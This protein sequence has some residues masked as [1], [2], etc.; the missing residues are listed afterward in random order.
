MAHRQEHIYIMS[1]NNKNRKR[2]L[3]LVLA[4]VAV[5]LST[6]YSNVYVAVPYLPGVLYILNVTDKNDGN[7][8]DQNKQ[9]S[10]SGN[11]EEE[12]STSTSAV[13]HSS[14]QEETE[15][16]FTSTGTSSSS[17]SSSDTYYP[18]GPLYGCPSYAEVSQHYKEWI[19]Q[20]RSPNFTTPFPKDVTMKSLE[21][22]FQ[23]MENAAHAELRWYRQYTEEH[24]NYNTIGGGGCPPGGDTVV[25][26]QYRYVQLMPYDR[27][28]G[29][30]NLRTAW[31]QLLM[32]GQHTNRAAVF[33][34]SIQSFCY[35]LAALDGVPESEYA[36]EQWSQMKFHDLFRVNA[37]YPSMPD[38]QEPSFVS[39]ANGSSHN[40]PEELFPHVPIYNGPLRGKGMAQNEV[41][42][43]NQWKESFF[44]ELISRYQGVKLVLPYFFCDAFDTSTWSKRIQTLRAFTFSPQIQRIANTVLRYMEHNL[45]C[46]SFIS[47]HVRT[48]KI[49][50]NK[51]TTDI[52]PLERTIE[53]RFLNGTYE[54]QQ[55]PLSLCVYV[56]SSD[57]AL[58]QRISKLLASRNNSAAVGSIAVL[59]KYDV[60]DFADQANTSSLLSLPDIAMKYLPTVPSAID[61]AVA[62]QSDIHIGPHTS[63][64]D[65]TLAAARGQTDANTQNYNTMCHNDNDM[66]KIEK[67]ITKSGELKLFPCCDGTSRP[68]YWTC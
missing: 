20:L 7:N 66:S 56:L 43:K 15:E 64:F 32:Y 34:S 50:S 53:Q 33:E 12:D 55:Q 54:N 30:N 65:I 18:K 41:R 39:S 44:L 46:D 14:E 36:D 25:V 11:E 29:L 31:G 23:S 51:R 60:P 38:T 48:N 6:L 49:Y 59:N 26:P 22:I 10:K 4:F 2:S 67:G 68:C 42:R 17:Y 63:S 5:T 16:L 28:H 58:S 8:D 3:L 47:Y 19:S 9:R 37:S 57:P 52:R 61:F 35:S 24:R 1:F 13:V 45:R 40:N 27:G 21:T 62:Q